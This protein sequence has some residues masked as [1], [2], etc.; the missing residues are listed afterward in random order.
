MKSKT[1]AVLPS[2]EQVDCLMDVAFSASGD[3]NWD[4]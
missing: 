3:E 1:S 2:A 4:D